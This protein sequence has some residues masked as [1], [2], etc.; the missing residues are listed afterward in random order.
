MGWVCL[1]CFFLGSAYG[2]VMAFAC[3]QAH[4]WMEYKVVYMALERSLVGKNRQISYK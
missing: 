1:V 3:V 2:R 4:V